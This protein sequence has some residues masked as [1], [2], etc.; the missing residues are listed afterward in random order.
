MNNIKQQGSSLSTL[1][2]CATPG[3]SNMER[4]RFFPRQLLTPDDLMQ[5]QEYFRAKNRRHNRMLHGW[6]V[7][8]GCEV[9]AT[10]DDYAVCVN[11][12]Y[13]LGPQGDE[14]V[15]DDCIK[16]D[17]SLQDIDGNTLAGC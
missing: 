13:L 17:L 3:A 9:Q 2:N 4:M 14:I 1:A 12:G 6:G 15:I 16:V 5:E 8:C 11:P 10:T 7:V